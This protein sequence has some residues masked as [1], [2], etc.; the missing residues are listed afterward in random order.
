MVSEIAVLRVVSELTVRTQVKAVLYKLDV[1]S[2]I[3]A[4][5]LAWDNEG[6]PSKTTHSAAPD[7]AGL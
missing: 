6:A 3:K 7:V 5:A 1:A 4:V 2:Q